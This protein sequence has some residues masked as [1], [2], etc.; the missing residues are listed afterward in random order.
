MIEAQEQLE[1]E[2]KEKYAKLT[3]LD[4]KLYPSEEQLFNYLKYSIFDFLYEG[5][6]AIDLELK[7]LFIGITA[8]LNY[9]FIKKYKLNV[10]EDKAN[11]S[12]KHINNI[13]FGIDRYFFQDMVSYSGYRENFYSREDF[14]YDFDYIFSF[15]IALFED[16]KKTITDWEKTPNWYYM[17]KSFS[18]QDRYEYF[19]KL[20]L[21]TKTDKLIRAPISLGDTGM[22][23]KYYNENS[24][25]MFK[26]IY[27][28][29]SR[30][31]TN[32]VAIFV[33]FLNLNSTGKYSWKL[34]DLRIARE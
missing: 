21:Y 22:Y 23:L 26:E 7:D 13:L 29:H 24:S 2:N 5:F 27:K 28:F 6:D 17:I 3:R 8:N 12:A 31:S 16:H 4:K 18:N 15:K 14:H 11:K 34:E 19:R 10:F 1:I 30:M 32:I 9:F 25:D 33:A 20:V